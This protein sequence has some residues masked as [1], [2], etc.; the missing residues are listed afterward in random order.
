VDEELCLMS[1]FEFLYY[2][3]KYLAVVLLEGDAGN[4]WILMIPKELQDCLYEI[5]KAIALA[6]GF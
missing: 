1:D 2:F 3:L 4:K 5:G 6:L